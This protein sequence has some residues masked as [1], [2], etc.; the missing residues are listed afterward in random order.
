MAKRVTGWHKTQAVTREGQQWPAPQ[1]TEFETLVA[2][3]GLTEEQ[4]A[5]DPEIQR[6]IKRVYTRRF[7]PEAILEYM[8]LFVKDYQLGFIDFNQAWRQPKRGSSANNGVTQCD[9]L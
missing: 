8:G 7:V 4:A 6:W 1:P 2:Q 5:D 3:K 9:S